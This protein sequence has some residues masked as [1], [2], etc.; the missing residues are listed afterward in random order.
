MTRTRSFAGFGS[1][2]SGP[3]NSGG[4]NVGII[5]AA[6]GNITGNLGIGSEVP[7]EKLDVAGHIKVD[8][9]PVLENASSGSILRIT[10]STGYT[11]IGPKNTSYSHFY[12]DRDRYYFNK[13]IIVDEGVIA[14][15]NEDLVLAT[16]ID[17]ERIRIK[18]DDGHIGIGTGSPAG[19]LHVQN[20]D[21][22]PGG[23]IQIW[24][25]DTGAN[26]R[27]VSLLAPETDNTSAPF[28]FYTNNS[29]NFRVDSTDALTIDYSGD[30]GI[31]TSSPQ[32]SLDIQ[33]GTGGGD[34]A[35]HVRAGNGESTVGL[36]IDGD[37][38]AGDV[39]LRARS[40]S[41]ATP[42]DADTKFI[43]EGG[44]NIGIGTANPTEKLHVL[45]DARVTGDFILP[46]QE[47]FIAYKTGNQSIA[48]TADAAVT[49]GAATYDTGSGWDSSN[50]RYTVQNSGFFLLITN[51]AMTSNTANE[52]RDA[53]I[54]IER[55]TDSG[56]NW[57]PIASSAIRAS[58]T[59]NIDTDSTT[60]HIVLPYNL[61]AGDYL[62]VGAYGNTHDGN[63]YT[64]E[65]N[66][67]HMMGGN[68]TLSGD[69]ADYDN[70]CTYFSA[71]KIG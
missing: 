37:N 32:A 52:L 20:N 25:A 65:D 33:G 2:I 16:D 64:V 17:E 62:R 28:T 66:V 21:N 60:F 58:T 8:G 47:R 39:L 19:P 36:I 10:S 40:N 63:N 38:E 4:L 31:R 69:A 30:V 35:V 50:N 54:S 68:I 51:V 56:S 61:N 67:N 53:A 3:V 12:T 11:E 23:A 57:T 70:T 7:A 6:S 26:L 43:I 59:S 48:D 27:N 46:T 13:K 49:F 15:Y 41:T 34:V 44:G 29:W 42:S 45:G 9:G 22:S 24:G 1:A 55:S 18:A 14:S 71:V 5:T